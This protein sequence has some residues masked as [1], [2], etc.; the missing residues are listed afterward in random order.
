VTSLQRRLAEMERQRRRLAGISLAGREPTHLLNVVP[1]PR[2]Y[3]LVAR[4]TRPA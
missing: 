2:P 1:L 4:T 3:C